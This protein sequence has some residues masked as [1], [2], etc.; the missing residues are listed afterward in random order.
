MKNGLHSWKMLPLGDVATLQRGFDLPVQCRNEGTI[1]VFAANGPV[2]THDQAKVRGPGVVTGRSGTIGAVHFVQGDYWPL[3]TSLFVKDFHGNN[4]RFIYYLLKQL[5]LERF[6]EGTGVPTLNRNNVHGVLVPLPPLA[7]QKRIADILD[8]ADAIRRK[9]QEVVQGA[10]MLRHALYRDMFGEA[11]HN[12]YPEVTFAETLAGGMRNGISPSRNGNVKGKVL[13]LSAITG[14]SFDDTAVKE[15]T[16]ESTFSVEQLVDTG[17]FLI[18]R[19]NGNV[20]LVGSGQF[21]THSFS[22]TVF[23]DT[24]IAAKIDLGALTPEYLQEVWKTR[25]VRKQI[26]AG[27]RTTNGTYKVNQQVLSAIRLPLPPLREQKRFAEAA[28][29][30]LGLVKR[31]QSTETPELF[32]SLVHRAFKGAL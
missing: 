9:R 12:R 32:Q 21:P 26:E 8:K 13:V 28:R 18:C 31:L 17:D 5:R 24:M 4:P 7:E 2:G 20:S 6:Y 14:A 30:M 22:D 25:Y 10:G 29:Q 19:G 27:A 16:F 15:G 11:S 1:P 3:N 23:P